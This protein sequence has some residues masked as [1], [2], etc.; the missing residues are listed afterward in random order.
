MTHRPPA[1]LLALAGVALAGFALTTTGTVQLP[2]LEEALTD[3][4][5]TLGTWTYLLVGGLAFLETGAFVGLI[6]PGET[7]VVL[8][9]VVAAHG[10]VELGLML[11][12]VW[13]AAA[14]GDLASFWLGRRLGRRFLVARGPRIG[15]TAP[16][17]HRVDEFFDRHGAKAIL[18]GR[19]VGIIRAVAPFLA[20]ASGMRVRNFVPWSLLGTG[21]W[22]TTFT[23]VGY[24]FSSSF[25]AATDYV[26]NGTLGLAVVG[27]LALAL[28]AHRVQRSAA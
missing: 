21:L 27:G 15:V 10:E 13:V 23:L 1:L 12:L 8:G 7:A 17:L 18:V 28:R 11:G 4:S 2:D 26:T 14:A 3:L 20:G 19:F 9:G 24:L 6:A 25:G 16:R 5:E 22:A